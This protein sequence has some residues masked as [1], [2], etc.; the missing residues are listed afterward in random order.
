MSQCQS[1]YGVIRCEGDDGHVG[2]HFTRGGGAPSGCLIEN[3]RA[4]S[5]RAWTDEQAE[6]MRLDSLVLNVPRQ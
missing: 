4:M 3:A 2:D 1:L 5:V 6:Q